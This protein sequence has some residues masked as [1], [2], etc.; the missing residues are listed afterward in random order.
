MSL[1]VWWTRNS[2]AVIIPALENALDEAKSPPLVSIMLA[3][4][5]TGAIQPVKELAEI[6][7]EHGAVFHT[8]A[9][10]AL[11]HIPVDVKN[12]GIDMLSG[13]SHKFNGP[14]GVGF[15][16]VRRGAGIRPFVDGGSQESGLRAGTENVAGIVGMSIAL[17][18]NCQEILRN[19][20]HLRVL[21]NILL[22]GLRRRGLVFIR[23]GNNTM[24]GLVS[25]SF[26][27]ED[28]ERILHRLD[29][30]GIC[31]ST[32]SAC[33]GMNHNVSHVI[34]SMGIPPEYARGTVRISFGKYNTE[35][36][37]AIIAE[38]LAEI[39]PTR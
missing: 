23:N 8:D 25:L 39:I 30:K 3:N 27:N 37:A 7:H 22:D 13:S 5:E 15:L 21:E 24:P 34:R 32:G 10:Q 14:R 20:S 9:V 6:S 26:R 11:G 31:V 4:N 35:D 1:R 36:E 12:L 33:D 18:N 29:L 38:A 19:Q 28:G 2:C 17:E 16:Y